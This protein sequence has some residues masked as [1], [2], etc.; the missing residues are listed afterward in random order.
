MHCIVFT[1]PRHLEAVFTAGDIQKQLPAEAQRFM[2]INKFFM[3]RMRK[4]AENP[5]VIFQIMTPNLLE[6]FIDANKALDEIQKSLNEYLEVKCAA[7]PRFY[8]LSN[9]E[10]LEILSQTKDPTRVQP[11]LC[12]VFEGRKPLP[13]PC[14]LARTWRVP[15]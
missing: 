10:L 4:C 9:D 13:W 15:I 3:D 7:F 6:T 12:K 1:I 14:R 5:N 8:F 2:K 11:F